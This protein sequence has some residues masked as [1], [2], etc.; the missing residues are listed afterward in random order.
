MYRCSDLFAA[1]TNRSILNVSFLLITKMWSKMFD[2]FSSCRYKWRKLFHFHYV[3]VKNTTSHFPGNRVLHILHW[4]GEIQEN[5]P[6]FSLFLQLMQLNICSA[7]GHC[8]PMLHCIR[9]WGDKW[10]R[11]VWDTGTYSLFNQNHSVL[12]STSC[13]EMTKKLKM[14][15]LKQWDRM[16]CKCW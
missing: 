8:F 2:Q 3:T 12:V 6:L 10:D 9:N 4:V 14:Q 11:S 13:S 1:A 15:T 5:S 16:T 7:L